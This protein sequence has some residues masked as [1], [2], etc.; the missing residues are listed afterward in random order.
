MSDVVAYD[1]FQL[2]PPGSRKGNKYWTMR[3]SLG[4]P[5]EL[6]TR[7][8]CQEE[9]ENFSRQFI[10]ALHDAERKEAEQAVMESKCL[11]YFI[12]DGLGAVKI[13]SSEDP[14]GRLRALQTGSSLLLELFGVMPGEAKMERGIHAFFA[15]LRQHGEWF[16]LAPKLERYIREN[17]L[18]SPMEV[19]G[20]KK[21]PKV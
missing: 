11:I 20:K 7:R 18:L 2:Y 8:L 19:L 6:S 4:R 13:G 9:A 21:I 17:C 1:G 16:K 12:T 3:A 10:A 15:Y 5:V 14:L